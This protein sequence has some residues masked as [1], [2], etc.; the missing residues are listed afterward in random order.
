M[1]R[2]LLRRIEEAGADHVATDCPLSALRIEEGT[3]RKPVHP[4]V[5]L[6][7]AYG[8]P[9][10]RPLRSDEIVP[11]DRYGALRDAYRERVIAH[12]R[13]RRVALGERV[14]AA[15]RG[16]RDAA[17]PGAGDALGRAH[18]RAGARSRHELDVYNELMPGAGELSA[19]LFIEITEASEIRPDA[20]PADRAST[21]TSRWCSAR[22]RTRRAFRARFDRRQLEEE[23]I[24]AVQY[25]R[26]PLGA[27]GSRRLADSAPARAAAGRATRTTAARR[28]SRPPCA[29]P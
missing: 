19:T 22:A 21:S 2:P 4:I 13:T 3:G 18:P 6:R 25:L 17:L 14:D 23:R 28:R 10:V 7:H 15:L 5:L 26:F 29:K 11:L 1:A 20:R 16:P 24:S 9:R 8:P 27:D 12:K